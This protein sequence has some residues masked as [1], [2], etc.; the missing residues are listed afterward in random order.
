METEAARIVHCSG[1][2][3]SA[4]RANS[5]GGDWH[6]FLLF[7]SC[8]EYSN[9]FCALG[10]LLLGLLLLQSLPRLRA[11]SPTA[12]QNPESS[13]LGTAR[14]KSQEMVTSVHLPQLGDTLCSHIW[15]GQPANTCL[16]STHGTHSSVSS[17]PLGDSK[18]KQ[19]QT[20]PTSPLAF[21]PPKVWPLGLGGGKLRSSSFKI[22][23]CKVGFFF[24]FYLFF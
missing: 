16:L 8:P 11:C 15:A 23:T 14:P 4:A 13:R 12:F 1:A 21:P 3:T 19:W 18:L 2:P 17:P 22:T 9:A 24:P 7:I 6:T 20:C 10:S 5:L